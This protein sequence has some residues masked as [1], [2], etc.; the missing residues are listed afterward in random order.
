MTYFGFDHHKRWTQ[1]VA[2]DEEG[3][4]VRERRVLNDRESL[5]EFLKELP[6]PWKGVVEAGPSWG[7]IYDTLSQLGVEMI[8]AHP[9]KVRAIAEAKIKTD[10][11]DARMLAQLLRGDLIP[12][13][14][15]PGAEVRTQKMVWRER[16]WL[17]RM[18]ARL[19][20]R[21]HQLLAHHHVTV[22]EYSDLF[23]TSGRRFLEQ[24]ELPEQA[25][26]ILNA[27]LKLLDCYKALIKEVQRLACEATE[28]HPYRAYLESLPGFGKVFAPIVA[29]EIDDPSRFAHPGKLASYCGLV[30]SLYSSGG[31]SWHGGIGKQG[32]HWLKWAFIE[33][34]WGAIRTSPYFRLMYQRLRRRKTAAV[35]IVACAR[36]LCEIAW[37]LMRQRRFYEERP[38]TAYAA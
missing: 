4:I 2:V 11:I 10:T 33:G 9:M 7:W 26:R 1:A 18:S 29:L 16:I 3:R 8:V 5:T 32:N 38:L 27:Q 14:Y 37:Q 22:P 36:R 28:H 25:R 24:V 35:A 30:P 19:K 6:R 21:V 34:A 31:K 13:V 15:V 12:A 20:C 23:G 17:V